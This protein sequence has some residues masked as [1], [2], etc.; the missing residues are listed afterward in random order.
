MGIPLGLMISEKGPRAE[1]YQ[2]WKGPWT[3][4]GFGDTR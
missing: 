4:L 3:E 1:I 2:N